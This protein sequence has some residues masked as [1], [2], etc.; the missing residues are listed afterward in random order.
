[1]YSFLLQEKA[2]LMSEQ[3]SNLCSRVSHYES[4]CHYVLVG[5]LLDWFLVLIL[6]VFGF[7]LDCWAI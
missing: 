4:F 3:D 7:I 2:Y 5:F 1:M 6:V